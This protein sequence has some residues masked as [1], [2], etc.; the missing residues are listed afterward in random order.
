MRASKARPF[1]HFGGHEGIAGEELCEAVRWAESGL[2]DA[3]LGRGAIEQRLAQSGRG[4]ELADEMLALEDVA[5][6]RTG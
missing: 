6:A 3:V 1:A 2:G 4:R 5:F